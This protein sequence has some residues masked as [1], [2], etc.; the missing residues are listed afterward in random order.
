MSPI[1]EDFMDRVLRRVGGCPQLVGSLLS[2]WMMRWSSLRALAEMRLTREASAEASEFEDTMSL[3]F[4]SEDPKYAKFAKLQ[5]AAESA[6]RISEAIEYA[7]DVNSY[8]CEQSAHAILSACG[9][10]LA[11]RDDKNQVREAVAAMEEAIEI[12]ASR[13]KA[14]RREVEEFMDRIASRDVESAGACVPRFEPSSAHGADSIDPLL[15]ALLESSRAERA[16]P[17]ASRAPHHIWEPSVRAELERQW[18][19]ETR[20]APPKHTEGAPEPRKAAPSAF[21][22]SAERRARQRVLWDDARACYVPAS[23]GFIA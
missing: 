9:P 20:S 12:A 23:R 5:Y 17:P 7:L 4:A 6:L 1:V 2:A 15:R 21:V 16:A 18:A 22:S 11:R 10:P 8:M 3:G 14:A 13:S 19:A